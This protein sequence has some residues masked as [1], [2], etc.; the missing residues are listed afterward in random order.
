MTLVRPVLQIKRKPQ[1]T[2]HTNLSIVL[3]IALVRNDNDGERVAV[4]HTQNLLMEMRDFIK[5]AAGG[6]GVD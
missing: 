1:R 5:R 3:Q 6:D 2:I 4:L